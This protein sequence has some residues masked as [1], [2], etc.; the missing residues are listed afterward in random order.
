[1]AFDAVD[2]DGSNGLDNEEL[3]LIINEV[4]IMMNVT[5]PTSEDLE[6]ILKSLDDDFD[7]VISKEEFHKLVMMV[8]VKMVQQEQQLEV[9]LNK[10]IQDEL[11]Y[12]NFMNNK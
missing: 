2:L 9:K 4:S 7:G 11:S 10:E 8:I 12:L 1:M 3:Y 6:E 5:P